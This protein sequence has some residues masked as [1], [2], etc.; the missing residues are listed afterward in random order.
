MKRI[1]YVAYIIF[2]LLGTLTPYFSSGQSTGNNVYVIPIHGE[3]NPAVTGHVRKA[4]NEI[5][6]DSN[7]AL[8][9]FEID[10]Y[11][12]RIDAAEEI[13]KEILGIGIPTV[14]YVNTKAESAGVLLTIS[15]D[16][17]VMAPAGTIGSAETIPNTEKVLSMWTSLLRGVAEEKDRDPNLVASMADRSISIPG[18]IEEGRLLNLTT[19]EAINLGLADFSAKDYFSIV[20]E[21]EIENANIIVM[22]VNFTVR[23]AQALSSSYVASML[24]TIGFIGFIIEIF[25]AGFGLGGTISLIA[26]AL[27]FAG[28]I[29]AGNTGAGV[30]IIFLAGVLLLLIEAVVPGFGVTGIGGIISIV[31]SIVMA[32]NDA[33]SATIY[34]F[35]ALVLSIIFLI[36]LLKYGSRS[37][38][39]D[40]IILMEKLN[41]EKGYQAT[42]EYGHLVG[43]EGVV[44]TLLR[45]SGTIEVGDEI[46][47]VVSDVGFV[48]KGSIVRIVKVE[49]RKIIV[50]KIN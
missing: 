40:K 35:V 7:A 11:G 42:K 22:D 46:L 38:F 9:I 5:N 41:K 25:T 13:S 28:G 8:I 30:L 18:V 3:I 31:I 37:K 44:L 20:D 16:T 47:D 23:L 21:L 34:I 43:K 24:I 45:P 50:K 19:Q 29:L 4:L 2:I 10:T 15:G 1:R 33:R 32:A 49:G 26:F 27:Y 12:G 39:F 17:I 14:S 48:E 36:L 6:R